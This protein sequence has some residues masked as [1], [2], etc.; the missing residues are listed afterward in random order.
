[1]KSTFMQNYLVVTAFVTIIASSLLGLSCITLLALIGGF[2]LGTIGTYFIFRNKW[3]QFDFEQYPKWKLI[4]W[5][6]IIAAVCCNFGWNS[7]LI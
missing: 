7:V 2:L 4:M 3:N 6:I 5:Q 1:M